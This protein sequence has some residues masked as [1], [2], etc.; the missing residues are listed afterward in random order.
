MILK[1][2]IKALEELDAAGEN[3][4][5][6]V[7]MMNADAGGELMTP[8]TIVCESDTDTVWFMVEDF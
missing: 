3:D 2:L 5:Y 7:M 1:E 6:N 4:H 8:K